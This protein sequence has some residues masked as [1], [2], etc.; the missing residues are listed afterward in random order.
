MI[1]SLQVYK[2]GQLVAIALCSRISQNLCL[3]AF[4][5][6]WLS[7]FV[8]TRG[9]YFPEAKIAITRQSRPSMPVQL[10][11]NSTHRI[12]AGHTSRDNKEHLFPLEAKWLCRLCLTGKKL[13]IILIYP[14]S[15]PFFLI[16]LAL[17]WR[18][19]DTIVQNFNHEWQFLTT[20]LK[21]VSKKGNSSSTSYNSGN[22]YYTIFSSSN[23]HNTSKL[24]K[25]TFFCSRHDGHR[26]CK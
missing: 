26:H 16:T 21:H 13:G 14:V 2:F 22:Q 23:S 24:A 7:G 11:T 4:G 18:F 5:G 1:T 8:C 20:S 15:I 25:I 19:P 17:K 3:L 12:F 9:T 10:G 6:V